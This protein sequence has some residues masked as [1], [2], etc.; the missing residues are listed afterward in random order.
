MGS[1]KKS[2]KSIPETETP[3]Q[4]QDRLDLYRKIQNLEWSLAQKSRENKQL[5]EAVEQW[6]TEN[7]QLSDELKR[8]KSN[9]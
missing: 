5:K 7:A 6:E 4:Q 9:K 1:D 2:D 8:S 3:A